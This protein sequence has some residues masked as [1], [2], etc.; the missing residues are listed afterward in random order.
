LQF[1]CCYQGHRITVEAFIIV[2]NNINIIIV[3]VKDK[4]IINI[5]TNAT[6]IAQTNNLLEVLVLLTLLGVGNHFSHDLV[7]SALAAALL[8]S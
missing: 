2:S 3:P 1:P 5:G 7:I 4:V 6:D 8:P